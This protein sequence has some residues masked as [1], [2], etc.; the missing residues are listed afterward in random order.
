M[1]YHGTIP[2]MVRIGALS[3]ASRGERVITGSLIYQA[4]DSRRC[5]FPSSVPVEF[6]VHVCA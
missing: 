1:T 4:C 3:T 2:V 5:L 6:R